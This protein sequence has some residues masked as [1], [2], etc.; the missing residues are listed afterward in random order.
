METKK[1]NVPFSERHPNLNVLLGLVVL[2]IL[3][4]TAIGLIYAGG[5]FICSGMVE[6]VDWLSSLSS[7]MDAVVIVALI[8]G[9]VSIVGVIISSI[10]SKIIDYRKSRQEYLAKKREEPY[11]EFVDMIYK[12]QQNAKDKDSYTQE[13]MVHDL[14]RFS[15]QITLWG[16]SNVVKKWVKFRENA[17]SPDPGTNN[18]LLMEEIMNEMRK[19]LG[20]KKVNK[21]DLLSFFINDIKQALKK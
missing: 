8:T 21:G 1:D 19:D 3:L 2:L 12:V 10:V 18:L 14:F 17:V 7:K 4:A 9:V 20:L 13:E 5:K 15:K 16:S 11:G 6:F